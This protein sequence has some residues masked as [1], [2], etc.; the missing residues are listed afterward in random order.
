LTVT[1]KFPFHDMW[2]AVGVNDGT[3]IEE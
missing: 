1:C 3:M 2:L